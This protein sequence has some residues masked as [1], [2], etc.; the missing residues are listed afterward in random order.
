MRLA[1]RGQGAAGDAGAAGQ[2]DRRRR[3]G[4]VARDP[5]A[6]AAAR[7]GSST[8]SSGTRGP[9]SAKAQRELGWVPT[10]LEEGL[11][12]GGGRAWLRS[13]GPSPRT[14]AAVAGAAPPQRRRHVRPLRRRARAR[15]E[16]AGA[17]A[18]RARQRLERRG[19]LGGRAG[20]PGGRGHGGV[21]GRRGASPA[22]ALPAAGAA[23]A[24]RRGAG[25]GRCCST[26]SAAVPRP[27]P[28]PPAFYVDALATDPALRRRGAARALLAEAERQARER[29]L[30]AVALDTTMRQRAA[31]ALCT[32]ARASRR[33]PTARRGAGCPASW[34]SSSALRP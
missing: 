3:R 6:A 29:G 21:P 17:L 32:R 5:Q 13:A 23:L 31:R 4:A 16:A 14:S 30:P 22:R 24:R 34:R 25:R 12:G 27:A 11:R 33:W 9:Q 1:G 8:S 7:A 18:R 28:P 10:P 19:G 26:G 15:A 20:R 2:G